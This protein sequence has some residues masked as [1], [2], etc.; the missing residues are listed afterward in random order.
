MAPRQLRV[1]RGGH[2]VEPLAGYLLGG[3]ELLAQ[4]HRVGAA[5]DGL[6]HVGGGLQV[7]V[8]DDV[9]VPAA[10]LVEVGPPGGGGVGDRRRHRDVDAQHLVGGRRRPGAV[11][12]DDA[13]RAG[14][15]QVR[16]RLVVAAAA[17]DHRHVLVGD[18]TLEVE[19]LAALLDM[20]GGHDGALDDQHVDARG[21]DD[22]GQGSGVLRRDPDRDGVSGSLEVD[23]H[24]RQQ[25]RIDRCGVELLQQLDGPGEQSLGLVLGRLL[26]DPRQ[27]VLRVG[28]P[29]PQP[30]GV[31]HPESAEPTDLVDHPRRGDGV[32]R[33]RQHRQ[34]EAV[35]VD[36]PTGADLARA[37]RPPGRHDRHVAESVGLP[38]GAA[39]ADL[40]AI[41]HA[42]QLSS[43]ERDQHPAQWPK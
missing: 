40:D 1:G 14:P 22:R 20:F 34:R 5:G 37:P 33:V 24:L 18:E 10:G 9:H 12:D 15:H 19:R 27:R 31:E 35:G 11:A 21:D 16:R 29:G 6:D 42:G 36:L 17:D 43:V 32:R 38:G 30:F 23:D 8:G 3:G 4:H 39:H 13:R 41:H 28:V 26:Q 7:A 2:P 25:V